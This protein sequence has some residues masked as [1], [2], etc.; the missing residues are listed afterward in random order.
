MSVA[1]FVSAHAVLLLLFLLCNAVR[2]TMAK[3]IEATNEWQLLGENDTVAAGMHIRMDMTTG[4]KWVKLQNNEGEEAGVAVA[5]VSTNGETAEE[6][7]TE[8]IMEHQHEQHYDYEMM[9][10]TLSKLPKED[11]ERMKL[12]KLE[13]STIESLSPEARVIFEARMKQIWED[14]QRELR[15]IEQRFVADLPQILRDRIESINEYLQDPEAIHDIV[16]TLQDLEHQLT[17]IDMSRDFHTLGG[18]PVLASLLSDSVHTS[19]NTTINNSKLDTVHRIQMH[20]AWALGSAV[21][22]TGEFAPFVLEPIVVGGQYT[23]TALDL[24]LQQFRETSSTSKAEQQKMLKLIYCLGSFL[25]G[26]HPAQVHFI[27]ANGPAT[28]L[29]A[30]ESALLFLQQQQQSQPAFHQKLAQRILNLASD[31][32]ADVT[33]HASSTVSE[34][35]SILAAYSTAEWCETIQS[36]V[37]I[38][39]Q[40][41]TAV[42]TLYTITRH[43]SWTTNQVERIAHALMLIQ[44]EWAEDVGLDENVRRERLHLISETLALLQEQ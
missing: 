33:V 10:R 2:P 1:C 37:E 36:A 28:M 27:H 38:L 9:H 8:Q 26:N 24:V 41:D 14:R 39:R 4:E 16:S 23:T 25:R 22:N 34:D 6:E 42:Q 40:G 31:T 11:Q 44:H 35:A 30:L 19:A 5:V 29:N 15:D 12:P 20:A 21:K 32:I 17:D 7:T 13:T 3:E 18:W 43:C